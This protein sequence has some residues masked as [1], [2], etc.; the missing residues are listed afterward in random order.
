MTKYG[1]DEN[2]AL[3]AADKVDGTDVYNTD[4]DKLGT[5]NNIMLDKRTG[6][7]AYAE[8]SFGGFLGI[9]EQY[10]PLPWSMLEYDE[11]KEGYV[12]PLDKKALEGAPNYGP[13]EAHRLRDRE[14]ET[15]VFAFYNV[16]PYWI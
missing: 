15:S 11:D 4:G 7:V 10:H 9:G 14:Y 13:D 1:S 3:I 5:V 2:A 16:P 12:V 8:M 6:K